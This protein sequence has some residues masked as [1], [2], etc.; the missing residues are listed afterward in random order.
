MWLAAA[1][2]FGVVLLIADE[3]AGQA[4][5]PGP[6]PGGTMACAAGPQ[7]CPTHPGRTW[8][9]TVPDPDQCEKPPVSCPPARQLPFCNTSLGFRER[10]VD[11]VSRIP[12]ASV[13]IGLLSTT[14]DGVPS[15]GIGSFEWCEYC[16]QSSSF[17]HC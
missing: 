10:A 14:S 1:V 5:W 11:L 2:L 16:L 12:N 8:C 6:R 17:R 3:V 7:P 15:L 9:P 13:K 4:P